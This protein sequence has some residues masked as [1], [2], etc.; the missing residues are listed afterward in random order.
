MRALSQHGKPNNSK[1]DMSQPERITA[2]VAYVRNLGN[3]ENIRVHLGV[4]RDVPDGVPYLTALRRLK[5]EVEK[6]VEDAV[7][8]IDAEA[9][10]VNIDKKG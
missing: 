1:E 3:F 4:E 5:A 9:G 10:K 8:E 2:D 7:A 6:E